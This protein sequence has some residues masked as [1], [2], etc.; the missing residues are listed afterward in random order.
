MWQAHA[1]AAIS[2]IEPA[3]APLG[4]QTREQKGGRAAADSGAA[5]R[6]PARARERKSGQRDPSIRPGLL[7]DVKV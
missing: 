7:V 6:E 1:M 3:Y 2:G 5:E 4:A